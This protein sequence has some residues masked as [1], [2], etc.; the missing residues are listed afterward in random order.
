LLAPTH[1]SRSASRGVREH[2]RRYIRDIVAFSKDVRTGASREA[3][4]AATER[5]R[6]VHVPAESPSEWHQASV[7]AATI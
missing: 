3:E 7:E 2:T 1:T 4:L 5:V 6:A